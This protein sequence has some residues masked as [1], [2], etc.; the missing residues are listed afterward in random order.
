[1]V[2]SK[3]GGSGRRSLSAK[4]L[5]AAIS[6]LTAASKVMRGG[7]ATFGGCAQEPYVFSLSP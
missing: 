4:P 6:F 7:V 1:M 2:W 3:L 5:G